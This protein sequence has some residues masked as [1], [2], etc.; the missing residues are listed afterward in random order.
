MGQAY[1]LRQVFVINLERWRHRR[2][3]NFDVMAQHFDRARGERRVF[4]ASRT[5]AYFAG[6]FQAELATNRFGD[7]EHVGTIW[8]ANHLRQ[9][10][11]ISQIDKDNATMI[12][13][14]VCPATQGDDLFIQRRIEV[15]TVVST[16]EVSC[17]SSGWKSIANVSGGIRLFQ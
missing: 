16:H 4:C 12:T 2:V 9:T 17:F 7:I 10:S 14:T 8:I 3:E 5:W 11:A 15:A 1:G 13:A 6:D